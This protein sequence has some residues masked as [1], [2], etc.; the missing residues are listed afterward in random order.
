MDREELDMPAGYQFAVGCFF[1]AAGLLFLYH[2]FKVVSPGPGQRD[3][4]HFVC[5]FCAGASGAF[6]TGS[7]LL[8]FKFDIGPTGKL[9]FQGTAGVSLFALVFLIFRLRYKD[10]PVVAP[11]GSWISPS[12]VNPFSQI[13]GAIANEVGATIDMSALTGAEKNSC[14]RGEQLDASTIELATKALMRLRGMVSPGAVREYQVAY[15]ADRR[16]FKIII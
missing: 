14:P 10:S 16:E 8:S 1:A 4:I 2:A 11:D 7:A 6:F 9:A 3:I 15:E 13:A 5:A 12:G